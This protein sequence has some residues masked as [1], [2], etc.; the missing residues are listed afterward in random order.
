MTPERRVLMGIK[1]CKTIPFVGDRL[2]VEPV[3]NISSPGFPDVLVCWDGV[4]ALVELKVEKSDRVFLEPSQYAWHRGHT[5]AGGNCW[6]LYRAKNDVVGVFKLSG[7]SKDKINVAS[8]GDKMS[9][10]LEDTWIEY[11]DHFIPNKATIFNDFHDKED[12]ESE[13]TLTSKYMRCIKYICRKNMEISQR[14]S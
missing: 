4:Y 2:I 6:L 13:L 14:S 3:E 11:T 9:L 12:E 7:V 10:K 8:S 5:K 1:Q